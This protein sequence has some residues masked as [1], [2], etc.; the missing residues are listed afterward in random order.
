M[1]TSPTVKSFLRRM[2]LTCSFL[3]DS[4][5]P[6]FLPF[7][8]FLF[9][10]LM[11]NISSHIFSS[12]YPRNSLHSWTAASGM[13]QGCFGMVE[14]LCWCMGLDLTW[15]GCGVH[16]IRFN[17]YNAHIFYSYSC[18]YVICAFCVLFCT[19]VHC[20]VDTHLS[21]SNSLYTS[22][23]PYPSHVHSQKYFCLDFCKLRG[24]YIFIWKV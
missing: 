24:K 21:I 4:H 18:N 2:S 12:P 15:E 9:L 3:L 5:N 13:V 14:A 16:D 11:W 6:R 7:P 22:L 17:D 8:R 10:F 19:R 1:P 20:V 23:P